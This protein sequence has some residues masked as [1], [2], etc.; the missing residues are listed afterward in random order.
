MKRITITRDELRGLA[1]CFVTPEAEAVAIE[2]TEEGN[3]IVTMHTGEVL[4][5]KQWY[6]DPIIKE[7]EGNSQ[8]STVE[9]PMKVGANGDLVAAAFKGFGIKPTKFA[10]GVNNTIVVY[11]TEEEED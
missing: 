3:L 8:Y 6:D 10:T 1:N 7:V 11:G 4:D 5:M 9:I 2:V